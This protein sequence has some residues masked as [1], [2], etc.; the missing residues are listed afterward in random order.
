MNTPR[1]AT[2]LLLSTALLAP[3]IAFAQDAQS[4]PADAVP[5]ADTVPSVDAMAEAP[6]EEVQEEATEVSIPGGEIIVTGQRDRNYQRSAPQVVSV[7]GTAEIARTGEGNIAGA[8]GRVTGLSVVGNGYVYVRGL[9]DRYSL[10]LLNGMPLPSP[11]PLKR[12]VPLDLFPS[13]IIASTL[14]QKS[15]SVN[16][17]GEFG[18]G[19]VNLTTKSSPAEPFI[20]IGAGGAWDSETTNQLGYTYYGSSTD[21]TGFD[22]GQR[23]Y[24]NALQTFFDSGERLSSGTLDNV[25]IGKGIVNTR[26]GLI[27]KIP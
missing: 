17:P 27:Q 25:E 8:L 7:L 9:G 2:L 26:N 21:W 4:A 6:V 23:D 5:P 10:A 24:T 19:V 12:V 20:T 1:L 13:S 15:Y 22:N 3:S 14:V 11:E 16:Y 18:G